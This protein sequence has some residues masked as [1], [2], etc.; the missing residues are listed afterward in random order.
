[1]LA[2]LA[3]MLAAHARIEETMFYPAAF[4]ENTESELREAVEE[5][6]VMKRLIADLMATEPSDP[7][8]ASK[9]T[10]LEEIVQ[11]HVQEE[12]ETLFPMVREQD[13]EDLEVLGGKL[14]QR[15]DELMKASPREEIPEEIERREDPFA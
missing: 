9:V 2:K 5:H 3:D 14:R 13:I 10:V 15:Y 1:M 4:E 7:Q 12:E 6:L 11:H 8:F